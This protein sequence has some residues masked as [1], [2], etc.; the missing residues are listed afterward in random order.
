MLL[1]QDTDPNTIDFD[2][3]CS[4]FAL[5]DRGTRSFLPH[6]VLGP[7]PCCLPCATIVDAAT[8]L[9]PITVAMIT[10]EEA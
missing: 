9:Q 2:V 5:C 3:Q 6:P 4:W 1:P 7:T 8:E 10:E